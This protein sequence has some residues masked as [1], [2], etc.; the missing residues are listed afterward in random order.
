MMNRSLDKHPILP[1]QLCKRLGQNPEVA[2]EF[3]VVA[4]QSK[5]PT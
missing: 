1:Q 4:R 3:A 2:D 5:E